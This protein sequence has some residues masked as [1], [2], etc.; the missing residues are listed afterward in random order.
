MNY[1]GYPGSLGN[2][3]IDYIIADRNLIPEDSQKYY[4]EK[5]LYLPY[6]YQAQDDKLEI[7][8]KI[9]TRSSLSLPEEGFVFCAINNTYKITSR[10]FDIWARLLKRVR[11]SILWLQHS[12]CWAKNN[13]LKEAS[14]R[15]LDPQA[16]VFAKKLLMRST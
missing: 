3:S 5:L 13:L 12:N 14:L 2:N 4:S 8:V 11:G 7:D 10:E 16:I 6:H 9:P 15:G 1:L